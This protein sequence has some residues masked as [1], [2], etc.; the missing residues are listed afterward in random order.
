MHESY[1]RDN[2]QTYTRKWFAWANSLFA[3]SV[4]HVLD[5]RPHLLT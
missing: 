3:E 5:T 1:D 4:L 2:V